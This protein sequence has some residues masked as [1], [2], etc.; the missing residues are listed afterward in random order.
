MT[1]QLD[2]GIELSDGP[3]RE[4]EPER[5]VVKVGPRSFVMRPR[6]TN[7]VRKAISGLF[8]PVRNRLLDWL[9]RR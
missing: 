5:E 2:S 9:R 3:Q 8:K 7:G 1:D 6:R 4:P